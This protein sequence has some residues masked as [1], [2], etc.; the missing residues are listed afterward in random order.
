SGEVGSIA[1]TAT[2]R[3]CALA[4]RTSSP[5]IVDF[6]T[7]GEPVSPT[8][9]AR[10]VLGNSSDESA[11]RPS[12]PSSTIEIARATARGSPARTSSVRLTAEAYP[13]RRRLLRDPEADGAPR[14]ATWMPS[15]AA[16]SALATSPRERRSRHREQGVAERGAERALA[17]QL[18]GVVGRDPRPDH[19]EVDLL[20]LQ[21]LEEAF[22]RVAGAGPHLAPR[23]APSARVEEHPEL[24]LGEPGR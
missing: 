19:R 23:P 11:S 15:P 10:P 18:G 16:R 4:A 13:C 14:S 5:T 17:H 6:P 12:A 2:E 21:A 22:G 1:S 9:V 3:P 24:D 8:V 20:L 7:P